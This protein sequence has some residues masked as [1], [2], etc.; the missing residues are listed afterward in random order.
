MLKKCGCC[1]VENCLNNSC[2]LTFRCIKFDRNIVRIAKCYLLR[3]KMVV[4]SGNA[5][6]RNGFGGLEVAC[7]SLVPKFV[8]S[9]PAEAVELFGR[10]NPHHV[11]LRRGSKTI[12]PMSCFTAYKR[13]LT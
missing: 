5:I 10:K 9:N 12:C 4:I 2:F 11:F 13:P 3:H 7:W 6:G 1:V 8:G